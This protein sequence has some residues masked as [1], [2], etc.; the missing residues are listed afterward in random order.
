MTKIRGKVL[1]WCKVNVVGQGR[2]KAESV[3]VRLS[4]RWEMVDGAVIKKVCN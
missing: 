3:K 4:D 1:D 2:D